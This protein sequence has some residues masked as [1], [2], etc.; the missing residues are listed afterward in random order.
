MGFDAYVDVAK[1]AGLREADALLEALA[2]L[3]GEPGEIA[4]TLRRH[5]LIRL[6]RGVLPEERLRA[7][8]RPELVGA[9]STRRPVG[10]VPVGTLLRTFD[11]VRQALDAAGVPILVLKGF[12]FAER[13]YGGLERRPQ[14][15]VDVLVRPRDFRRATALLAGLGFARYDRDLHSLTVQRGAIQVD[16]HRHLRWAPAFAIDED[17][18]WGTAVAVP[19]DGIAVPTLSDEYAVVALVLAAFED[20]GQGMAKLKQLLDLHL[21]LRELDA[22][23]DWAGFFTRRAGENLLGVAVNV[24][25]LV[26]TLF[27]A[28]TELPR[29]SGALA[30]HRARTALV[31]R[32]RVLALVSAP[33]KHPANLAWFAR[34]YPGSLLHYLVWFWWGG[35]PANLRRLGPA[36]LGEQLAVVY[37]SS[38]GERS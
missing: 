20:V 19:I 36:W 27:D 18:V 26:T 34:V 14:H 9:L 33:A 7:R 17:A 25:A 31:H 15:D 11:E 1:H 30:P 12:T 8:L 6:V 22:A 32:E 23:T 24:L 38:R 10:R 13:L 29:L 3:E 2:R 35:F 21:L 4:D 16:V 37:R 5:H 28:D